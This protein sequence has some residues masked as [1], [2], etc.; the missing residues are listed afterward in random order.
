MAFVGKAS[1]PSREAPPAS[2]DVLTCHVHKCSPGL[3]DVP[4]L[5]HNLVLL[6]VSAP[7]RVIRRR[8]GQTDRATVLH[9]DIDILPSGTPSRWEASA[10]GES[11]VLRI[12]DTLL[13]S[14][15]SA[16]GVFRDTIRLRSRFQLRDP[17]IE[18]VALT[19]KRE[20]ETGYP[21][22]RLFR[23][24][25]G[26][27]LAARLLR[28]SDA[29]SL[30]THPLGTGIRRSKLRGILEY[31]EGN[32]EHDLALSD[33]AQVASMSVSHL[34]AVFRRATGLPVHQYVLR[35]R[36]ECAERLLAA[37][38]LPI[39]EVAL[40]AGFANQSHLARHVRRL[41][42]TTPLTIRRRTS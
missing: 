31:I 19:L 4:A 35:R 7:N 9:G 3:T 2:P 40:A 10:P 15:A 27:A 39:S 37:G 16:T 23:D 29:R 11:L 18:H 22:G 17:Q 12:P 26:T 14:V 6:H 20:F 33:I 13:A 8:D 32:L 36:V 1:K 41:R 34:K 24:A 30:A 28:L 42:G 5:H 21:N 38:K 25:L